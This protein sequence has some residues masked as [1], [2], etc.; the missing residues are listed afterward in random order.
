MG[1]PL[2]IR[3]SRRRRCP[4]PNGAS[5]VSYVERLVQVE[6]T[7]VSDIPP[8]VLLLWAVVRA[9]GR[10]SGIVQGQPNDLPP[11]PSAATSHPLDAD[12]LDRPGRGAPPPWKA[13]I[14]G[15]PDGGLAGD[16]NVEQHVWA[17]ATNVPNTRPRVLLL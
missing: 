15:R 6:T 17:E 4:L 1:R 16:G 14:G 5:A 8:R 3:A 13:G 12:P 10:R 9:E 2:I 7:N 11:L